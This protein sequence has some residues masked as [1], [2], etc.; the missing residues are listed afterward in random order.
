MRL[1]PAGTSTSFPFTVS[2]GMGNQRL[3]LSP[4]LLDVGDVRAD[5]A[6][7]KGA[8]RRPGPSYTSGRTTRPETE[9]IRV[10]PWVLVPSPANH[11]APR[12]MMCGTWLSVS[13]LFTIVGAPKAPLMAGKGGLS[14]GQPFL[15]SSDEISPVSSPQMY[16]PAPRWTTI[17][18]PF[19]R[20]PAS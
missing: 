18:K 20:C 2:L 16:A 10:P 4:E 8:D 9:Y 19:P 15:P 14:F 6:V 3:E 17:S 12:L 13:T 11:A 1:V 7:V 5:G